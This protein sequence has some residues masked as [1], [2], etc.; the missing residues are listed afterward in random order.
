MSDQNAKP[1]EKVEYQEEQFTK[2]GVECGGPE[3]KVPAG[4]K[5]ASEGCDCCGAKHETE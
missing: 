5:E 4:T 3:K 2:L 1:V